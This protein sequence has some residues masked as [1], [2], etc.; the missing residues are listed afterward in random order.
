MKKLIVVLILILYGQNLLPCT[1]FWAQNKEKILCA[2]NMDWSNKDA[3]MLFIPASAGKYGRV[4]FGVASQYGFTNTSGMN[5]AG[6][7]YGGASLPPR[8][9]VFNTYNKPRWDYEL[10]EKVMEECSTVQEA[11]TVFSEYWE[12]HWNGHSLIADKYGHCVVVSYGEDDVEFIESKKDYQV[13]TNFYLSDTAN[14]RWYTCHRYEIANCILDSCGDISFSL[15]RYIAD[16]T[17]ADGFS[18][19]TVL[20]NIH[21]LTSGDIQLVNMHNFNEYLKINLFEELSKGEHYLKC[22][23][24]FSKIKLYGPENG[25]TVSSSN[26]K[27]TWSGDSEKYEL[28][29]SKDP[30]F[31]ECEQIFYSSPPN[32]LNLMGAEWSVLII[33]L[34]I[35]FLFTRNK[36]LVILCILCC[37]GQSC[38]KLDIE[39][40]YSHKNHEI[41]ISGLEENTR[42]FWKIVSTENE[43]ASRSVVWM[44]DT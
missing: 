44:F 13:I 42:Y 12:P 6:L 3:R 28:R 8:T 14:A 20:T 17:H 21:D 34:I 23:D 7:W 24:Y 18:H 41:T 11:I 31:S 30:Y 9:D 4:Y 29:Y 43:Y 25:S 38:E 16:Q 35:I 5:E 27:I 37:I 1:L 19:P 33:P 10:I 32:Q 15:F 39:P 22:D 26:V 40:Q 36:T 2:K